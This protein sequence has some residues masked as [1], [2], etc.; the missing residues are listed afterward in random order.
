MPIPSFGV[1]IFMSGG[2]RSVLITRKQGN[3]AKKR[4][5]ISSNHHDPFLPMP[6]DPHL[7]NLGIT[8]SSIRKKCSHADGG[9]MPTKEGLEP[10]TRRENRNRR[11]QF[12]WYETHIKS[13]LRP[14]I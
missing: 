5:R 4:K 10:E 1:A 3:K 13:R 6:S 8:F 7:F 9:I 12:Q 2:G 14:Y 11:K